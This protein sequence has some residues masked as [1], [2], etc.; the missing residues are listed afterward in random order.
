ME[1]CVVE[2]KG[3]GVRELGSWSKQRPYLYAMLGSFVYFGS[4]Y[5]Q[6]SKNTR[7]PTH[8]QC[9]LAPPYSNVGVKQKCPVWF[10]D[11]GAARSKGH[12]VQTL[13]LLE[14]ETR[15]NGLA[16]FNNGGFAITVGDP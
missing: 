9:K 4:W 16:A 6:S 15:I 8:T 11:N 7:L 13:F 2:G 3:K 12:C 1:S 14:L 10:L 5:C